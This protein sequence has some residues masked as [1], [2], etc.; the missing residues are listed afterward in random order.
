M[1]AVN[2]SADLTLVAPP[3]IDLSGTAALFGA[4]L[5]AALATFMGDW[6]LRL[7]RPIVQKE[8]S[9]AAARAL[10]L[11]GL[12]PSVTLSIRKVSVTQKSVTFQPVLGALGTVLSTDQPP[13]AQVV[14]P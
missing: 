7:M 12:P 8:V 11:V 2:D 3:H 1:H 6:I 4:V 13:A 9:D 10:S 14:T 5:N